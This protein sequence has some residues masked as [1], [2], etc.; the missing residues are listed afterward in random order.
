MEEKSVIL[1]TWDFTEKSEYAL[2]H[3]LNAAKTLNSGVTLFHI[4]KKESEIKGIE[5]KLRG[6]VVEHCSDCDIKPEVLVRKGNIFDTIGDTAEEVGAKMVFMG[7]HGIKGSQKFFG[8]WALKVISNTK[9]P[10]IVVQD[11]PGKV[12]SPYKDIVFPVNY[13]KENKESINWVS[14]FA[15]HF[16]SKI[17]VF[18]AK[19][20]DTKFKKGVES[21]MLFLSKNFN[22]KGV[23]YE[24]IHSAGEKDFVE[25]IVDYTQKVKANAIFV[26]TTK[27][28]GVTDYM[29]GANEQYIIA[30]NFQIPVICVNPKPPKL[31]GGF[32][33]SA[34]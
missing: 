27:D 18:T 2:E 33:T 20:T 7:T 4:A 32:S 9:A 1:V 15:N 14:Y 23:A 31:S 8:S 16:G 28:I 19:H 3:A 10:F 6:V 11:R 17:H 21:N 34:G 22:L 12:E 29:L 13:R 5:D 30:N 26:M 25:E 24:M